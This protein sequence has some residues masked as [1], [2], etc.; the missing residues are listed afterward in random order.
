MKFARFV[1]TA[2]FGLFILG[3]AAGITLPVSEDSSLTAAGTNI[4][5]ARLTSSAGSAAAL[6]V[7]PRQKALI[8]FEAGALA[9]DLPAS[10]VGRALLTVYFPKVTRAGAVDLHLVTQPWAEANPAGLLAPSFEATPFVTIPASSVLSKQFAIVDVT[11]EVKAWLNAPASDYGFVF[12]GVGTAQLQIAS[13]EGAGAG[14]PAILQIERIQP[15]N[16]DTLPDG[17]ETTKIGT[18]SVDDT[19]FGYLDGATSVLQPQINNLGSGLSEVQAGL[20]VL[21]E[22]LTEVQSIA[23][24]K[25]SRAG[26]TMAGP[27]NLPAN[28]LKVGN[29][30]LALA[31]GRVGIGT[32]TPSAAL[33]VRGD[34]KLGSAGNLQATGGEES[35]RIVRGTLRNE[36]GA[37]FLVSGEGFTFAKSGTTA[38]SIT[39]TTPFAAPPTITVTQELGPSSTSFSASLGLRD[40]T[41]SGALVTS[42]TSTLFDGNRMHFIAIGPR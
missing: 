41:A 9:G 31:D 32:A 17:I 37:V 28:G 33:E 15:I 14:H 2:A 3:T 5:Q 26:D 20:A 22:G 16:N 24:G 27:L 1:P 10:E 13:K 23:D 36:N 4:P 8:R 29:S 30:Q 6:E 21:Q 18:G 40:V 19:E 35:L 11:N 42:W 12:S 39:F 38:S 34:V 25:V 7:S